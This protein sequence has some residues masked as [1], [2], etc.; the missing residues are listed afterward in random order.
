ML[1]LTLRG[2]ERDRVISREMT[3]SILPTADYEF[4]ALGRSLRHF[5]GFSLDRRSFCGAIPNAAHH[6]FVT[7][8]ADRLTWGWNA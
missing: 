3:P 2:L 8:R 6:R 4:T 7:G 1:T 5:A